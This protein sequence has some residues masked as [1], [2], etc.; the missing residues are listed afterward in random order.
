MFPLSFT[1]DKN[2]TLITEPET[3]TLKYSKHLAYL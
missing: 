2:N 3:Y 1:R